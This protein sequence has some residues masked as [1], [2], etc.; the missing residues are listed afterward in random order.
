MLATRFNSSNA[1]VVTKIKG[2]LEILQAIH[3]FILLL[4]LYILIY[5]YYILIIYLLYTVMKIK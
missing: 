2:K 3:W 4:Y 1:D 5:T